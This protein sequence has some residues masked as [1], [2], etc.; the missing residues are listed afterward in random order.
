MENEHEDNE[1]V[2]KKSGEAHG[3]FCPDQEIPNINL[4]FENNI[5][6]IPSFDPTKD[7]IF[8]TFCIGRYLGDDLILSPFEVIFLKEICDSIPSFSLQELWT[9][10]CS[11]S[12]ETT[13]AKEYF[14]YRYYRINMWVVRDGSVFGSHFVLYLD[15]PDVVHSSFLVNILEDWSNVKEEA[16]ICSRIGW[17]LVK[18]C[19]LCV[20]KMETEESIDFSTPQCLEHFQ[21]EAIDVK[22]LNVR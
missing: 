20:V 14:V 8:K 4:K 15:H 19:I 22:R 7:I 5:F 6:F 1:I 17:T 9:I 18:K 21:I 10:C 16:L 2:F 3:K 13:F 11:L 12:K